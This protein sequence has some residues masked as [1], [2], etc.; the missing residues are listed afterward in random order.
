MDHSEPPSK[1][2]KILRHAKP[3]LV[4]V[5][6]GK[7]REKFML[8]ESLL[9]HKSSF[10]AAALKPDSS[11]PK[12]KHNVIKMPEEDASLFDDF[13]SWMYNEHQTPRFDLNKHG[14]VENTMEEL[15]H[16]F[17]LGDRLG[18]L[19]LQREM[20]RKFFNRLAGIPA[21]CR[22]FPHHIVDLI[23]QKKSA[24][25]EILK[26]IATDYFVWGRRTHWAEDA[27][28]CLISDQPEFGRACM[29]KLGTIALQEQKSGKRVKNPFHGTAH[30]YVTGFDAHAWSA[31]T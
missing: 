6:V 14:T 7:E 2:Q 9:C 11:F 22:Y 30:H 13:V 28:Q 1:R 26:E 17:D 8:P 29:K 4:L 5:E 3:E 25:I 31:I 27:F 23:Y 19:E 15:I 12:A 10:F 18:A 21:M 20:I 16:L 24:G